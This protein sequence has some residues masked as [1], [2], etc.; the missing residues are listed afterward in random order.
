MIIVTGAS[1][2]LGQA[3][4]AALR[5][6]G[7]DIRTIGRGAG[8]DIAR[9]ASGDFDANAVAK[10]GAATAVIHLAGATIGV[11]WT[12]PLRRAILDSRVR[13]TAVLARALA[14]AS[15]RPATWLSASAVGYYGDTGDAWVDESSAPGRGFLADTALAWEGATRAA[16]DAGVRVVP[17]R[18]GVVM[19]RGGMLAK[20]RLPFLLGAGGRIGS[21]R[22]WL[23]W[24]ALAD[25]VGIVRRCLTDAAIAGPVNVVSPHP[26][27]NAEF[28]AVF[29]RAL[30]RPAIV[31]V[32]GFAL[33]AVYGEM[34][35]QVLLAGQRVRPARLLALNYPFALADLGGAIAAAGNGAPA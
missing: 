17:L 30:H 21:G 5:A 13:L 15:P 10:I 9:P 23:S 22:Q 24:I 35:E 12:A 2:F 6:E 8:P 20:L 29:A 19:G 11:R 27:T 18:F 34:A 28:T 26:V 3:I 1:G 33:R 7:K 4:C 31:P 32:P 14:R 16:M 25:A